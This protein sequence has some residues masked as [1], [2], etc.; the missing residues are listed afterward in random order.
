MREGY[1][2]RFVCVCDSVHAPAAIIIVA[3]EKLGPRD[4]SLST[5]ILAKAVFWLSTTS[6][7]NFLWDYFVL[8]ILYVA[9]LVLYL[10]LSVAYSQVVPPIKVCPQCGS[11]VAIK[12]SVCVCGHS[13]KRK[14]PVYSIRK[15]RRMAMQRKR[16]AA[17]IMLRQVKDSARK[18]QKLAL[19]T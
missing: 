5:A 18:A 16:A 1:G 10:V 11:M 7:S 4:L 2:S 9:T 19:E 3:Q 13:F 15:S 12:K 6:F 14:L 17:E 8:Y